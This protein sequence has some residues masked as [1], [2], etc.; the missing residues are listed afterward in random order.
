M[1]LVRSDSPEVARD[2]ASA[3]A[4]ASRNWPT[5]GFGCAAS[6]LALAIAF[7][8]GLSVS[9]RVGVW[10]G[11]VLFLASN[12]YVLW[13]AWDARRRWIVVGSSD[14][15][16]VR[17]FAWRSPD[18]ANDRDP[19]VLVLG[20]SEIASLAIKAVAVYLYGPKPK[21]IEWLVIEPGQTISDDVSRHVRPL[22]APMEAKKAVLVAHEEG[23]LTIEWK[24][25]HPV[26]PEF[27]EQVARKCPSLV[28]G[29]E[30]R[31]DV[32]LNGIWNGVR[33]TWR[34]PDTQQRQL[35]GQAVR[36]G[37]GCQCVQLLSRHRDVSP[38]EAAAYLAECAQEQGE[39]GQ[40]AVHGKCFCG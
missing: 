38:R 12:G 23:R 6:V 18:H 29:R 16:Y 31:S 30:Q 35:L 11:A 15:L 14:R 28:I 7:A 34:K 8:L 20:A 22:L 4:W 17:L 26:L 1:E 21:L 36:L 19:D 5:L 25:W 33:W 40:P 2:I 9:G 10:A 37:F 3:G 32:D 39:T 13:R 27:F 24:W